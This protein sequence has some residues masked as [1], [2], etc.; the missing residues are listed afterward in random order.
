MSKCRT[1]NLAL[2]SMDKLKQMECKVQKITPKKPKDKA[3]FCPPLPAMPAPPGPVSKKNIMICTVRPMEF[4]APPVPCVCPPCPP[5][6]TY[7]E[8]SAELLRTGMKLFI[9]YIAARWTIDNKI[10]GDHKGT[11]DFMIGFIEANFPKKGTLTQLPDL[12]LLK[13]KILRA[14]DSAIGNFFYYSFGLPLKIIAQ[15]RSSPAEEEEPI[16][17]CEN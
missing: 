10:W 4:Q 1:I 5:C 17:W 2:V 6:K 12:G 15:F 3:T 8:R 14:W 7:A 9:M 11:T 16:D 13:Y